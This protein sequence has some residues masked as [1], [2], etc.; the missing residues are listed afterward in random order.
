MSGVL[1]YPAWYIHYC[2]V[3]GAYVSFN[4]PKAALAK[5]TPSQTEGRPIKIVQRKYTNHRGWRR[6]V[7]RIWQ[8]SV[9]HEEEPSVCAKEE[10]ETRVG[11]V[12]GGV[13]EGEL[14]NGM[15]AEPPPEQLVA[16]GEDGAPHANGL[17]QQNGVHSVMDR[18]GISLPHGVIN[19][20]IMEENSGA[21][22]PNQNGALLMPPGANNLPVTSMLHLGSIPP[23]NG[24][25]SLPLHAALGQHSL[26][27]HSAPSPLQ[28]PP[29]IP[30]IPDLGLPPG[31][32]LPPESLPPGVSPGMV[33]R[34]PQT[35]AFPM[36]FV[37]NLPPPPHLISSLLPWQ[38]AP[39]FNGHKCPLPNDNGSI[40]LKPNGVPESPQTDLPATSIS[41]PSIT[42]QPPPLPAIPGNFPL[43]PP[44]GYHYHYHH[45]AL[46]P[47]ATSEPSIISAAALPLN[48]QFL[49]QTPDGVPAVTEDTSSSNSL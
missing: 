31:C 37:V 14:T 12:N 4:M 39:A 46:P 17:P 38:V 16:G 8:Q 22:L 27:L 47:P 3:Y 29:F 11:C 6:H 7:T 45:V 30:H 34:P 13:V 48:Q 5:Q 33:I 36:Q 15:L 1:D 43:A 2:D 9:I 44:L 18:N 20:Q 49:Q 35:S 42:E 21:F 26:L 24:V 10:Q 23:Q 41:V 32:C 19:H 28:R 40:S 25:S